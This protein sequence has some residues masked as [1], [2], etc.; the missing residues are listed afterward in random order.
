GPHDEAVSAYRESL[1]LLRGL[2]EED[3]KNVEYQK[4]LIASH[5]NLASLE[6]ELGRH[7]VAEKAHKE[8]FRILEAL[9]QDDLD[10]RANLLAARLNYGSFLWHMGRIKDA[11][12][13]YDL[14]IK[15]GEG[16]A[17]RF[18]HIPQ[19]RDHLAAVHGNRGFFL[20]KSGKTEE[21]A[22]SLQK[23]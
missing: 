22:K 12:A 7:D 14:A 19:Y 6:E 9:P 5:G 20:W 11:E 15:E 18:K 17:A 23:A 21:A 16:L 1:D 4:G 3:P 13:T 8:V 10:R 2:A